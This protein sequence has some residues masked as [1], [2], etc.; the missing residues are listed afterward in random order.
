MIYKVSNK[1]YLNSKNIKSTQP[2]K[3]LGY[4]YHGLYTISKTI[5]K[6][7]YKL[8]LPLSMKIHNVFHILLL[9]PY[10]GI[11]E[12]NNSFSPPIEVEKLPFTTYWDGKTLSYRQLRWKSNRNIKLNKFETAAA[13]ITNFNIMWNKWVTCTQITN[14]YPR[15]TLP[16]CQ[17][18]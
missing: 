17:T 14:G 15:M 18:L 6:Q 11:N 4:K 1:I 2:T 8:E 9:E 7:A 13:T 3:K 5:G 16:G 12:P 10:T